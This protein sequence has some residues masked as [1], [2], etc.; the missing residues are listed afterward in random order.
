MQPTPLLTLFTNTQQLTPRVSTRS[1][2]KFLS[3]QLLAH[4]NPSTHIQAT[5]LIP[6]CIFLN[7]FIPGPARFP[8]HKLL[9]QRIPTPL[10]TTLYLAS[11]PLHAFKTGLARVF[12]GAATLGSQSG[13]ISGNRYNHLDRY[14]NPDSAKNRSRAPTRTNL[15]PQEEETLCCF[16]L[17]AAG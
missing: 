5:L 4:K 13:E 3:N 9:A 15:P 11:L 12:L 17:G 6:S 8:S 1:N 14:A 16:S 2:T 10:L 7:S